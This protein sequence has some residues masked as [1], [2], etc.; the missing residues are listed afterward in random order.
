MKL[1]E[2]YVWETD[3]ASGY[4]W[5]DKMHVFICDADGPNDDTFLFISSN[6]WCAD[7][8]LSASNYPFLNHDSFIACSVTVTYSEHELQDCKPKLLGQLSQ[9]DLQGLY[10][11][12]AASETMEQRDV[13]RLCNV[14]KVV[15]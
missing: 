9:A 15:V 11:A 5:R 1:G 4:A 2:V 13:V 10:K 8:P 7:Y 12:I 6:D 14:L 3:K